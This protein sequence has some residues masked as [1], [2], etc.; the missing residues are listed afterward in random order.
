MGL[1][2][3]TRI[4]GADDQC[5]TALLPFRFPT[6]ATTDARIAGSPGAWAP[7]T[8]RPY[9]NGTTNYCAFTNAAVSGH[10]GVSLIASPE[11]ASSSMDSLEQAWDVSFPFPEKVYDTPPYEL[12]DIP[13]KGKGLVATRRIERDRVILIDR[14]AVLM[15]VQDPPGLT[16]E[17]KA[18][19]L[20]AA[21]EQLG[22]PGTVLGLSVKGTPGASPVED[23]LSTNGF[24]LL[25]DGGD[26][27]G[28]FPEVSVS[29]A[30][31]RRDGESVGA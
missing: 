9:C 2:A 18:E 14:P 7:W 4:A 6:C 8:H 13:G 20:R 27:A 29:A 26:F 5:G 21:A 28:L 30:P 12:R 24:G 19:V 11:V 31:R 3:A 10:R 22:K 16:R 23:V 17:Q 25:L 15:P 1:L